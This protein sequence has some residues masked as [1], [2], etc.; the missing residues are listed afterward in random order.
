MTA[1][2]IKKLSDSELIERTEKAVLHEREMT[3]S[4][5]DH[6]RE[7]QSRR[8]YARLGFSSMFE[9]CTKHLK[10]CNASAQ[11]RIDAMR[12]AVELPE[13]KESL[14]N[15][16]LGLSVIGSFQK[17]V[18]HDKQRKKSYTAAEQKELL[19]QVETKSR[20]E[21]E[22][23]FAEISPEALP[24]EKLR[25]LN[26]TQSELRFVA[27]EELLE[28]MAQMKAKL[29]QKGN[30]DPSYLDIFKTGLKKA[31]KVTS[32]IVHGLATSPDEVANSAFTSPGE[33]KRETVVG[34]AATDEKRVTTSPGEVTREV[35]AGKEKSQ[36][37]KTNATSPEEVKGEVA[38]KIKNEVLTPH[39][40]QKT[41][42][43]YISVSE[44]KTAF[45]L[46]GEQ[47]TYISEITGKRCTEKYFLQV[48]HIV[49]VAQGGSSTQE[50]LTVLCA[51]HN[52]LNAI[53]SYG[54]EKMQPYLRL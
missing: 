4:V 42:R 37:I 34:K 29:R 35:A 40:K 46:A 15:G 26:A 43:I 47:C 14:E 30:T 54:L 19:K 27:D 10:Y 7:I 23:I 49:P 28:L 53:D 16:S 36:K 20:Q 22:K 3:N 17:F 45:E 5:L 8:L 38:Q 6:L 44:I 32:P 2:D 31:L 41:G 1:A 52:R 39:Q 9:Y 24:Q 48:E 21:A 12:L 50:N 13:I 11:L 18:R 33:V 51:C 25:V